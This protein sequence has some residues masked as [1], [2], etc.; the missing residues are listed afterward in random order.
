MTVGISLPA[1]GEQGENLVT[2]LL[3]QARQ[4]ADAGIGAV[5]FSQRQDLDALSLAALTGQAV[6]GV[7]IGTSVVPLY[8]RHPI[9]LAA[10]VRTAQAASGGRFQLGLGLSAKFFV[11]DSYG[12]PFE[13]PIRHLRE[14]L[15]ALGTLLHDG[16]IDFQGQTLRARTA[17]GPAGVPGAPPAPVLVAAMGPQAL[18]VTAELAD[19]VLPFLAAPKALDDYLVPTLNS[20]AAEAGRRPPRVVAM[21]PALVTTRTEELRARAHED[22]TFYERFP[23][24][25]DILDR[26]GVERAGDLFALGDEEAVA[27]EIRRYREAGA[28]EVV[29]T[30]TGFGTEEE[31]LRTWRLLGELARQEARAGE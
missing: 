5:W 11:E 22:L 9:T 31:R 1:G 2:T 14:Y 17:F 24:Y 29:V 28:S 10:Q 3:D 13:R 23:S 8:P 20:A 26:G 19:G 21:L 15:E 7:R 4:A 16:E 30:Q 18:R 6:P 12:V 25:R 27:A